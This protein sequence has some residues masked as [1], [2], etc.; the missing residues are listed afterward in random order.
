MPVRA[1]LLSIVVDEKNRGRKMGR[2]IGFGP[3]NLF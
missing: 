1:E 3:G 2:Q